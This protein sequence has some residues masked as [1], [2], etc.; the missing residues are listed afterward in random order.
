MKEVV[1]VLVLVLALAGGVFWW[2]RT[3]N[4]AVVQPEPVPSPP[5]VE[6]PHRTS[7]HS[8]AKPPVPISVP[9]SPAA[10]DLAS[11]SSSNLATSLPQA[12]TPH[13][14]EKPTAPAAQPFPTV[15]Q[16]ARGAEADTVVERYGEPALSTTTSGHQHVIE[17]NFVYA[18][19][20]GRVQTLI[21]VEDGK[22][23]SVSSEVI[24]VPVT[25]PASAARARH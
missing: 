3:E 9:A 22:V 24:P 18:R 5:P 10:V 1:I 12:E 21:H 14:P 19:D 23:V 11:A 15:D 8:R 7:P 13:H 20:R 4:V 6:A 2:T 25:P 17:E 16:V